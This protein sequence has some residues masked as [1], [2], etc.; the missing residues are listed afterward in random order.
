MSSNY[1]ALVD[2]M[3]LQNSIQYHSCNFV[4]RGEEGNLYKGVAVFMIN[5]FY[6][7]EWLK[8]EIDKCIPILPIF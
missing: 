2:E 6:D 5:Q 1:V 7:G 3:Y 8:K 4:G